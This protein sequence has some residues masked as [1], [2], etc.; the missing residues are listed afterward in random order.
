MDAVP[1]LVAALDDAYWQVR[2]RAARA[3]GLLRQAEAVPA[4]G[5][6]MAHEV[7]NLRKEA[8]IALG[9]IGGD[10]ARAL[11]DAALADPDPEV[12]KLARLGLARHGQAA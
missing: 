4:L 3:L 5:T 2:L 7:S 11:L 1:E 8:V 9:E 12:R 10:T 6:L